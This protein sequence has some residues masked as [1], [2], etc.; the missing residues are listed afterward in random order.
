MP[1]SPPQVEGEPEKC[2]KPS[3][4]GSHDPRRRDEERKDHQHKTEEDLR[5]TDH[6]LA[7]AKE[8]ES[9]S[10]YGERQ[11]KGARVDVHQP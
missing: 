3:R 10:R 8:N 9:H 1:L 7:V 2:K 6:L 4:H 5:T 11:K